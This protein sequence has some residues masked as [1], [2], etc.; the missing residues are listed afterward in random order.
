MIEEKIN[1]GNINTC[2]V[3]IYDD[4]EERDRHRDAEEEEDGL[5]NF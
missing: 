2:C 5:S 3:M 4:E 1:R